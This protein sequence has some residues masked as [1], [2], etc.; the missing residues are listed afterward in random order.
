MPKG[1]KRML[2]VGL[3]GKEQVIVSL[4]KS[5]KEM[6]SG[7]LEVF[8]TPSLV[9]LMEAASVNC[10]YSHLEQGKTTVGT[11]VNVKHTSATPLGMTVF[12]ESELC[13]IDG[14]RLVFKVTAYDK[15]GV[16]G[17]GTHERVIV[18]TERFMEKAKDKIH[19]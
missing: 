10:I 17:T 15:T 3:K 6:G 12:A 14:K 8:A 5:A 9:A 2:E 7:S 13:E 4:S 19:N 16:I 11:S 18:D 1:S